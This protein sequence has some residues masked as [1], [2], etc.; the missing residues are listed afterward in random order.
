MKIIF[1]DIDGPMIPYRMRYDR[2]NHEIPKDL[3]DIDEKIKNWVGY[4]KF[5]DISVSIINSICTHFDDVQVVISSSW[6]ELFDYTFFEKLF[7]LNGLKVEIHSNWMTPLFGSGNP[8]RKSR[9]DHIRLWLDENNVDENFVIIDDP[10]SGFGVDHFP[11]LRD[12]VV[13]CNPEY[14]LG[15]PEFDKV[16]EIL[17]DK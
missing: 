5:D 10:E 2:K 17:S 14:G 16:L 13:F 11:S 4:W 15:T 3:V 9:G 12:N 7:E 1:L 6:R 8:F